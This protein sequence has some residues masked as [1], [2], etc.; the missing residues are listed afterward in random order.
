MAGWKMDPLKMYLLLKMVVFQLAMLVYQRVIFQLGWF[1]H[2]RVFP[3]IMASFLH[4]RPSKGLPGAMGHEVSQA[5]L[6][7]GG[8]LGFMSSSPPKKTPLKI[9][10]WNLKFI[11]SQLKFRKVIFRLPKPSFLGV[12][13]VKFPSFSRVYSPCRWS[14]EFHLEEWPW[15]QLA[16]QGPACRANVRWGETMKHLEPGNVG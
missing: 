2:Q 12:Q 9:H 6:R 8:P 10:G 15:H 16:W 3:W 1:N 7:R 4:H 13:H 14:L 5:C 11:L